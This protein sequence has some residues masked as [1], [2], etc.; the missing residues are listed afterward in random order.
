MDLLLLCIYS[1]SVYGSSLH[2][3]LKAEGLF[4]DAFNVKSSYD[5]FNSIILES[6]NLTSDSVSSFQVSNHTTFLVL[7]FH[8]FNVKENLYQSIIHS[9]NWNV[10]LSIAI[11]EQFGDDKIALGMWYSLEEETNYQWSKFFDDLTSSGKI[12]FIVL[13]FTTS[14]TCFLAL[15]HIW[16]ESTIII[17]REDFIEL[18]PMLE[19]IPLA[20]TSLLDDIKQVE[21]TSLMNDGVSMCDITLVSVENSSMSEDLIT[22]KEPMSHPY[23]DIQ[24]QSGHPLNLR[25]SEYKRDPVS[26]FVRDSDSIDATKTR[27]LSEMED[28]SRPY[29][30][31]PDS[32]WDIPE[33]PGKSE[34]MQKINMLMQNAQSIELVSPRNR[35]LKVSL[36]DCRSM[37]S[38]TNLDTLITNNSRI[39]YASD[40]FK[41]VMVARKSLKR[42]ERHKSIGGESISLPIATRAHPNVFWTFG[43]P[44]FPNEASAK[45]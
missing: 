41:E 10:D 40:K 14:I 1:T 28:Y 3:S 16:R 18:L 6:L 38:Y 15:S 37:E 21:G 42:M 9:F 26:W 32:L 30:V 20:D 25:M 19:D 43:K 4:E 33:I 8:I 2:F 45:N 17:D 44:T 22:P 7:D 29:L 12:I 24:S 23:T 13:L 39:S 27:E 35:F 5:T 36:S 34:N 11:R 31:S